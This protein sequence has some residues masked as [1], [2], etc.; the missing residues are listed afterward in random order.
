MLD[1]LSRKNIND[2]NLPKQQ[3]T[4]SFIFSRQADFFAYKNNFNHYASFY[5][6]TFQH[7]GI[8]LEEM[9]IPLVFL[10]AR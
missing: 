1:R 6:N 3:I 7:G 4:S 2:I 5:R 9:L 8:S 10:K